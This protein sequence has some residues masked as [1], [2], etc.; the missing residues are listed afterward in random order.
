MD[1]RQLQQL[2]LAGAYSASTL[3]NPIDR[4]PTRHRLLKNLFI[5]YEPIGDLLN[6]EPRM[7][8]RVEDGTVVLKNVSA[9]IFRSWKMPTSEESYYV[10]SYNIKQKLYKNLSFVHMPLILRSAEANDFFREFKTSIEEYVEKP[11]PNKYNG[12]PFARLSYPTGNA[13]TNNIYIQSAVS[14]I[15]SS[16]SG[17]RTSVVNFNP[18]NLTGF[19][20][21]NF[22]T[23]SGTN[24]DAYTNRFTKSV[25]NKNYVVWSPRYTSGLGAHYF[26]SGNSSTNFSAYH[27]PYPTTCDSQRFYR[28]NFPTK[29]TTNNNFNGNFQVNGLLV[30]ST[31]DAINGKQAICYVSPHIIEPR[32]VNTVENYYKKYNKSFTTGNVTFKVPFYEKIKNVFQVNALTLTSKDVPSGYG[33]G[34]YAKDYTYNASVVDFSTTLYTGGPYT[35][36]TKT[37]TGSTYAVWDG[38]HLIQKEPLKNTPFYKFYTGLFTFSKSINTGTWDGIIPPGVFVN[39]E[40][41]STTLEED[42]G[43]NDDLYLVYS[44]IG[45]RDSLDQVMETG[46]RRSNFEN[47]CPSLKI[48]EDNNQEFEYTAYETGPTKYLA[49]INSIQ[50]AKL[51]MLKRYNIL[52]KN[53]LPT[54]FVQSYHWGRSQ[55]FIYVKKAQKEQ[56]G[57][58]GT[59]SPEYYLVSGGN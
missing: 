54:G 47:V 51:N 30:I 10:C 9:Q 59:I 3:N 58:R 50:S 34:L 22:V 23:G 41:L 29:I 40:L 31:G 21:Q 49:L 28:Y 36:V 27:I 16:S 20:A 39:V 12:L 2:G 11:W 24:L 26:S 46:F 53:V 13:N 57:A 18:E 4:I 8:M 45:S 1:T 43:L 14:G 35:Y 33:H 37:F 48:K 56:L 38:Q 5:D 17:S 25:K 52:I 42:I 55:N 19:I 15:F 44:G 7:V 32:T 6:A